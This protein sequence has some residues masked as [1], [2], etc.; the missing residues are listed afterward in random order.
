MTFEFDVEIEA[1]NATE[2]SKVYKAMVDL[3]TTARKEMTTTE[4]IEFAAKVKAKPSQI[5]VAKMFVK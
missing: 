5:K 3:Q 1:K 2:A 4:F